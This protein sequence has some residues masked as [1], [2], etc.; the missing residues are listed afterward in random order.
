MRSGRGHS[1]SGEGRATAAHVVWAQEFHRAQGRWER[2]GSE[3]SESQQRRKGHYRD[4][5]AVEGQMAVGSEWISKS[6][7]GKFK[8]KKSL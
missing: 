3:V 7:D 6:G 1:R 4:D 2:W 8:G 5:G